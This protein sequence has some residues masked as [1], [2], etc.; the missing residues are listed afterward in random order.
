MW[1]KIEEG[2]EVPYLAENQATFTI[3]LVANKWDVN[4][5]ARYIGE[6]PEASGDEVT[7][8]GITTKAHAVVDLSA[9]YDLNSAGRLYVKIDNLFDVQEIVSRR[10]YGARPSK[11]Q[12][13]FL[14]YQYSF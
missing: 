12:Q 10:P 6:M 11:I 9:H 14:G 2:D 4:L 13:L 7:L 3:G 1:G 8:S 5:I